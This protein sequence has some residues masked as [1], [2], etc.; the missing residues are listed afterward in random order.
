MLLAQ[1]KESDK[2]RYLA[3][4]LSPE[5]RREALAAL[6]TYNAE[7]ARVR[8]RVSEPLPGEMRLQYW[9]D[10]LEGAEHGDVAANPVASA[11]MKTVD[12][13]R[14]P[15]QT[16]IDMSE[17]RI[18][19]LYDDPMG[20]VN[21]FEGYAGETASALIQL[22]S[23][24]LDPEKA[25]VSA[26][27]AG[28]AGVAQTVAGA[29]LLLPQH[30]VRGQVYIPAEILS[31][32]GLDRTRFLDAR[33][34][35]RCGQ[36]IRA[37]AAFGREHLAALRTLGPLPKTIVSAYLPLA[38]VSAVLVK[39]DRIGAELMMAPVQ[40]GQLSRQLAMLRSLLFRKV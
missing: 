31:A 18:F 1:L 29:L 12:V 30:C 37:F 19:D 32:N 2:D 27:L 22:A 9:R 28:H 39:A 14:L 6:Y 21:D 17:A 7:L 4:L 26:D 25:L 11:L 13:H 38:A 15:R 33:D 10:L 40:S 34:K 23:F 16:L 20:S 35:D 8:E 3:T 5:D 24:V 36:A